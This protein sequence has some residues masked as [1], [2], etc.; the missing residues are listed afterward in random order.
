MRRHPLFDSTNDRWLADRVAPAHVTKTKRHVTEMCPC[1]QRTFAPRDRA[2]CETCISRGCS[3]FLM[4]KTELRA[5]TLTHARR[6]T[7]THARHSRVRTHRTLTTHAHS[8][9]HSLAR[10]LTHSLTHSLIRT[11]ERTHART[12][13]RTRA[14]A[15]VHTHTHTH[16]HTH[17]CTLTHARS[18]AP[19]RAHTHAHRQ[20]T[21]TIAAKHACIPAAY[22][23]SMLAEVRRAAD[24]QLDAQ[25]TARWCAPFYNC[26]PPNSRFDCGPRSRPV[27][28]PSALKRRARSAV[29]SP[30]PAAPRRAAHDP[31]VPLHGCARVLAAAAS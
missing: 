7:R 23:C 16:R 24:A 10:S 21:H 5:R 30:T 15:R 28:L 22:E 29:Y 27:H 14:H 17:A 4:R 18:R 19:S 20:H 8:L 3:A 31:R 1:N 25:V 26:S 13:A 11:H 9:T 2:A 12:H 6:R